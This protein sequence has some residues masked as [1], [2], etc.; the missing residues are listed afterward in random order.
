MRRS[1]AL[2]GTLAIALSCVAA[3]SFAAKEM[4]N[5]KFVD[6]AS[7]LNVG[8]INAAKQAMEK[9]K[10]EDVKSFAQRM[11]DDHTKANEQLTELA[12]QKKLEGKISQ[13]ADVK[14][15]A[16]SAELKLLSGD[17]FDKSYIKSQ[18][19]AHKTAI[20]TFEQEAEHGQDPELKAFAQKTLPTLKEHMELANNLNEKLQQK[21]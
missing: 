19:S 3:P 1:T 7:A 8:E 21:K 4:S 5:E 12:K 13:H 11:I 2:T 15:M 20:Q 14:S 10:S 6:K 18:V 16:S 9:S 17:T